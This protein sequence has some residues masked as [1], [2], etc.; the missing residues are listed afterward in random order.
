MRTMVGK[1]PGTF[2]Q[3]QRTAH[4][5]ITTEHLPSYKTL[6]R[7]ILILIITPFLGNT[8]QDLSFLFSAL[9][10]SVLGLC[11][12]TLSARFLKRTW[13]ERTLFT[14]AVTSATSGAMAIFMLPLC[15]TNPLNATLANL[16]VIPLVTWWICPLSLIILIVPWSILYNVI[17]PPLDFGLKILA[18]CARAFG[19]S[20][21][22][23]AM[24]FFTTKHYLLLCLAI[25]WAC[26]DLCFRTRKL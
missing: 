26:E 21:T 20:E 13:R 9:G 18:A 11:H 8:L 12:R 4:Y 22:Q 24:P 15:T 23:Q 1:I 19:S 16:V 3:L 14:L 17:I 5:S 2:P 25:L 10:A 7:T 6:V